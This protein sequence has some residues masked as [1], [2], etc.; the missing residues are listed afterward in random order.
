MNSKKDY[1][2]VP[3]VDVPLSWNHNPDDPIIDAINNVPLNG[4]Y[5]SE[6]IRKSLEMGKELQEDFEA[7]LNAPFEAN[8]RA[9]ETLIWKVEKAYLERKY[10]LNENY[11]YFVS[12]GYYHFDITEIRSKKQNEPWPYYCG[13]GGSGFNN[14]EISDMIRDKV[15]EDQRHYVKLIQ[16]KVSEEA[17]M[18]AYMENDFRATQEAYIRSCVDAV[19]DFSQKGEIRRF[20]DIPVGGLYSDGEEIYLKIKP[21]KRAPGKWPAGA[22]CLRDFDFVIILDEDAEELTYLGTLE[23]NCSVLT[24][25]KGD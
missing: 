14:S 5:P 7:G 1:S 9:W 22:I 15:N 11:F 4:C 16:D 8:K 21:I 12:P 10:A 18:L 24:K 6:E 19:S 25:K 17:K 23:S 3:H 2:F 13:A 20:S